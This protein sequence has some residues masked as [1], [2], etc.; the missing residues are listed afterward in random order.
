MERFL[1][2][3]FSLFVS[4]LDLRKLDRR[5]ISEYET[6]FIT[7]QELRV[8]TKILEF[9]QTPRGKKIFYLCYF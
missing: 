3:I 8:G 2:F 1:F 7:H 9:H 5:I 4:F 6:K